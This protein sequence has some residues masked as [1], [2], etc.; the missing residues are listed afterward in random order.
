M[1]DAANATVAAANNLYGKREAGIVRDS[2]RDR[3]II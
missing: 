2:F 3:G 1:P